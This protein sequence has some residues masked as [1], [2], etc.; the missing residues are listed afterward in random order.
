MA[1][2]FVE[3]WKQLKRSDFEKL[4]DDELR[5]IGLNNARKVMAIPANPTPAQLSEGERLM[6][7]TQLSSEILAARKEKRD[8]IKAEIDGWKQQEQA[9]PYDNFLKLKAASSANGQLV[10]AI[11]EDEGEM[12]ATELA[13]WCEELAS[14]D[15]ASFKELLD[16]LVKE[17]VLTIKDDKY[18]LVHI[19]TETLYPEDPVEWGLGILQQAGVTELGLYCLILTMMRTEGEPVNTESIIKERAGYSFLQGQ[20]GITTEDFSAENYRIKSCLEE[21]YKDGVTQH[22]QIGGA[23][24]DDPF[25]YFYRL[26]SYNNLKSAEERKIPETVERMSAT[27]SVNEKY[28]LDILDCMERENRELTIEEIMSVCPEVSGLSNQRVS[29]IVRQMVMDGTLL[30]S[31]HA[32]KAYF[33]VAEKED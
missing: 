2:D 20:E 25:Y 17:R 12:S 26:G 23:L 13:G 14:L 15:D 28:K 29:A 5:S 24:Y 4:S 18:R 19:C 31:E 22:I 10:A 1:T 21:M 27:Q 16:E 3:T 11:L 9:V 32:R 33:S 30:R 6:A 7:E 8:K